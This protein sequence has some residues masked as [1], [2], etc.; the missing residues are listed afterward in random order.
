MRDLITLINEYA[1]ARGAA[2]R[3]HALLECL[4]DDNDGFLAAKSRS[5]RV[6]PPPA[7]P[8]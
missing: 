3:H 4:I 8:G 5:T 7:T 6:P 1:T 2:E